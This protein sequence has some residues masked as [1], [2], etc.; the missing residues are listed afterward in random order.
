MGLVLDGA[1]WSGIGTCGRSWSGGVP[2]SPGPTFRGQT[3]ERGLQRG[4][5]AVLRQA[6]LRGASLVEVDARGADL[7]GAELSS[8]R[9]DGGCLE[10][11]NL[12]GVK[13]GSA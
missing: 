9:G 4:R 5:D 6:N 2:T 10:M 13:L 1:C 7:T 3:S 12:E 8:I 11:A